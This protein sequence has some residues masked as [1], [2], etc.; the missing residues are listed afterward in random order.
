MLLVRRCKLAL[1]SA[2]AGSELTATR[3]LPDSF[4]CGHWSLQLEL[5]MTP[6]LSYCAAAAFGAYD[7]LGRGRRLS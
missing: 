1:S 6:R 2:R 3:Q 5:L 4:W 7:H